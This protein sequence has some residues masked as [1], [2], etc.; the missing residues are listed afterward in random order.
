MFSPSS[1]TQDLSLTIQDIILI[2]LFLKSLC[3]CIVT[4][5]LDVKLPQGENN[6]LYLFSSAQTVIGATTLSVD[7]RRRIMTGKE[8]RHVKG[9]DYVLFYYHY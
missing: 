6:V 1:D 5:Q 4:F 8:Q 2:V 3:V 9:H 7:F